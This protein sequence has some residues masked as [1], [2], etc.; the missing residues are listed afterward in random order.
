MR[1]HIEIC[2][3]IMA[4]M[5]VSATT[6]ALAQDD[7]GRAGTTTASSA[8]PPAA[9]ASDKSAKA[10]ARALTK[11]VARVLSRTRGLDSSRVLV[12][13]RDGIVTLSGVVPDSGQATLAVSAAQQVP[14]V[15][16]VRNRLRVNTQ[17]G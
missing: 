5:C 3:A 10:A 14:G 17:S 13:V 11:R 16:A 12:R 9:D 6:V 15:R 1:V 8:L 7:A 2:R 4:L